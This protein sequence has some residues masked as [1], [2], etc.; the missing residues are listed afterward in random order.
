MNKYFKTRLLEQTTKR[1]STLCVTYRPS[2]LD[3]LPT[4]NVNF[5]SGG[6]APTHNRMAM[7]E[8]C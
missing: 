5:E 4:E 1:N 8:S 6:A 2:G 7:S 3:S